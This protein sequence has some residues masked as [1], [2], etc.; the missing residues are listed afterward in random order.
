ARRSTA[1]AAR[2]KSPPRAA[3]TPASVSAPC[4]LARR[5]LLASSPTS[6]SAIAARWA[7]PSYGR[8]RKRRIGAMDDRTQTEMEQA[9][10]AFAR[11][12]IV[13]VT[14]D[15]DRANAGDMFVAGS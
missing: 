10:A 1:T 8:S 4:R 7:R 6:F 9:I 2:P 13:V 11:G 12:E 15:D 5:W 14:D 3:T